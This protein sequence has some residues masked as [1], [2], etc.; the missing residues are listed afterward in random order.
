M[1]PLTLAITHF[2]NNKKII[3]TTLDDVIYEII[4]VDPYNKPLQRFRNVE[5]G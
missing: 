3:L 5:K 4:C 1:P 2:P